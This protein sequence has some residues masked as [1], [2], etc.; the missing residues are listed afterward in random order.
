M[1]LKIFSP[2]MYLA[3][4]LPCLVLLWW[5]TDSYFKAQFTQHVHPDI[6]G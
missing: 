1:C 6:E 5:K 3:A 2:N 4:L